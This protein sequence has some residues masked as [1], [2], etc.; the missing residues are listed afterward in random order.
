VR[1]ALAGTRGAVAAIL[2]GAIVH[3]PRVHKLIVDLREARKLGI[4]VPESLLLLAD[5]VIR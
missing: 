2:I 4:E 1:L 5:E 3:G